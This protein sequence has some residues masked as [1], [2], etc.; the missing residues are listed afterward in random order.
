MTND[1]FD[2]TALQRKHIAAAAARLIAQD[3]ADYAGAKRK[4][5]RQILGDSQ[6]GANLLPD[7]A[8]I[9]AEVRR[10]NALFLADS[11]PAHLFRLRGVALRVMEALAQFH[12][13]LSGAVFNGTAGAH[14][15]IQLQLFADSA[16]EVQ[17][18]LL[19]KNVAIDISTTPHFK[20]ARFEPVETV[21]F[22]WHGEGVHAALYELDDLRG[23]LRQKIDGR[24][25]RTDTAGLRAL[26]A[27]A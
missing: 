9:E 22:L 20:G 8:Q 18:F 27:E 11:Q 21:S 15:E 19:D 26:L 14:A 23:A 3:G 10:Y 17:I 1:A 12:P 24:A 5:A 25:V 6:G 7:N 13:H 4:A 16:K 2:D